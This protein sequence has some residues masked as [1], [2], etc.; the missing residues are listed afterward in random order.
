M[1]IIIKSVTQIFKV[2][3]NKM[4]EIYT[5]CVRKKLTE[6]RLKK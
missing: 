2:S 5:V 1:Y 4:Y 3:S 6:F